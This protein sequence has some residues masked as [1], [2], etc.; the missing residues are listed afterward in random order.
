MSKE[1]A[2]VSMITAGVLLVGLGLLLGTFDSELAAPAGTVGVIL[3]TAAAWARYGFARPSGE[4]GSVAVRTIAYS[5]LITFAAVV[6]LFWLDQTEVL[7]LDAPAGFG[8]LATVMVLSL[9]TLPWLFK[10]L[11]SA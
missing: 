10:R 8:V 9:S 11:P 6:L 5:W 7:R 2:Y 1:R 3:V 4:Q